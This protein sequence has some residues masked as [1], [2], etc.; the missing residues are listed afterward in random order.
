MALANVAVQTGLSLVRQHPFYVDRC[1]F[2]VRASYFPERTAGLGTDRWLALAKAA[3]NDM[4]SHLPD[5]GR[6]DSRRQ[7]P[8]LDRVSLW[9][10]LPESERPGV[11]HDVVSQLRNIKAAN[12][13]SW[14]WIEVVRGGH[15]AGVTAWI[16]ASAAL[17]S[18]GASMAVVLGVDCYLAPEA[19]M[20]LEEKRWLHGSRLPWRGEPRP[21]P[22]GRVPGEAAAA[23]ALSRGPRD[24]AWGRILGAETAFEPNTSSSL[25]PCT[26]GGL[27]EA[28][29]RAVT[30]AD[31]GKGQVQRIITDLN[32]EP[33]RADEYGFTALRLSDVLAE[34]HPRV[35]PVLASGD[36]GA[37]TAVLQLGLAA[38]E[39][40]AH[41]QVG[42]QLLLSSSDE[43]LRGA[44]LV[45]PVESS[46][47]GSSPAT[48]LARGA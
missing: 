9:I 17:E 32:G 45:A 46:E 28:A 29:R 43:T 3:L 38:W 27:S 42:I 15:A 26:G 7:K 21:N 33:Y 36:V 35:T 1:G 24:S 6:T 8:E 16:G 19:L 2:P 44:V 39:A 13:T 34:N 22:Y 40:R 48:L 12:G 41:P 23:V 5:T 20:W 10:V 31:L 30:G 11:P 37:A 47:K 18:G 4:I 25:R 14:K